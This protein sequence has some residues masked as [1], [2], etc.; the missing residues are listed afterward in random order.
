MSYLEQAIETVEDLKLPYN[1]QKRL[2]EIL[3]Y[4]NDDIN[5]YERECLLCDKED[6]EYERKNNDR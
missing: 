6:R 1:V 2:L 5:E 4:Y 3:D